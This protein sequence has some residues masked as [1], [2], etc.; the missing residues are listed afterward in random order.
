MSHSSGK[1]EIIGK[2]KDHVYLKYHRAAKDH[3]SGRFMVFKSNPEACWFDD[4]DQSI[5][6]CPINLAIGACAP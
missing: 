4:Y 1:I 3:D 6:D 5:E 2:T